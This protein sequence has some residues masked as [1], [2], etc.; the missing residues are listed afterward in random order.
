MTPENEKLIYALGTSTRSLKEFI[1][2]ELERRGWRAIHIID[3][4]RDWNL[5]K[6]GQAN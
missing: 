3:E 5:E 6:A 4:N 2:F 1:G